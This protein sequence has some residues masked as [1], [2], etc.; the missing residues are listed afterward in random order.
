MPTATW[1]PPKAA[2]GLWARHEPSPPRDGIE[3]GASHVEAPLTRQHGRPSTPGMQQIHFRVAGDHTEGRRRGGSFPNSEPSSYSRPCPVRAP[4][5]LRV[6]FPSE[7]RPRPSPLPTAAVSP[8]LSNPEQSAGLLSSQC[9]RH[10]A[11][12]RAPPACP[13]RAT[14]QHSPPLPAPSLP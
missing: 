10:R 9:C 14:S 2:L 13:S 11:G 4:F 3:T 8:T 6:P 1:S 5:T 7:H 12:A